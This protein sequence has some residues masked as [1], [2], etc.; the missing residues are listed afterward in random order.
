MIIIN[1]KNYVSGKKALELSRKI[2]RY[3]PKAIVCA[4]SSDISSISSKT[5]L[6]VYA[7]H[8]DYQ[9]LG[10]ST[11]FDI[12]EDLKKAGASGSLLNHSEHPVS[13]KVIEKTIKRCNGKL[14]LIV[15]VKNLN[16]AKK[17]LKRRLKPYAIAFEDPKLISSGK[18]ITKYDSKSV[19]EF[20]KL[21]KKTKVIP[22]CGAGISSVD[23]IL[24]AKELGCKGVLVSS[25]IAKNK[26]PSLLL[27]KI[28]RG[29]K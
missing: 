20:S 9:D 23:D 25:A 18:S 26:N 19:S 7:Q 13:L 15:C 10:K 28:K 5:K 2:K 27:S 22:I 24:E 11:G 14:K 8:V 16:I 29:I 1:Y 12:P 3:L 6:K 4:P 21:V 17:I